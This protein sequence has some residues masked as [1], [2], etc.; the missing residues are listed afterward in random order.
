MAKRS[1][2]AE[3]PNQDGP[4]LTESLLF[5]RMNDE[6]TSLL[7]DV[8]DFMAE[9]TDSLRQPT[10]MPKLS[11]FYNRIIQLRRSF[12]QRKTKAC[13]VQTGNPVPPM[14]T[15]NSNLPIKFTPIHDELNIF[16]DLPI[17]SCEESG[18]P[19]EKSF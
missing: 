19:S 8:L 4:P 9:V 13:S 2:A 11:C 1:K 15:A 3:D 18:S 7:A 12:S 10:G 16:A 14:T 5:I 17:D 6:F